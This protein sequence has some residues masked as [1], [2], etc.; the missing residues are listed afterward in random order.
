MIQEYVQAFK[1]FPSEK[2]FGL[3]E[4]NA[5]V[6]ELSWTGSDKALEMGNALVTETAQRPMD[7][8][9][10]FPGHKVG[11]FRW[12]DLSEEEITEMQRLDRMPR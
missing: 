6:K 8:R 1:S 11:R 2:S 12:L 7:G 10:L 4:I 3:A 5:K 9:Q